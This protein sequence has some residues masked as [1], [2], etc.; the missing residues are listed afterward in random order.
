[1]AVGN[2]DHERISTAV[3]VTPRRLDQPLDLLGQQMLSL[4]QV[5]VFGAGRRLGSATV[6]FLV[7]GGTRWSF[8]LVIINRL[9]A[10]ATFPYQ[11]RNGTVHQAHATTSH[12]SQTD[13]V[14]CYVL[15][16]GSAC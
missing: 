3:P 1:M 5:F 6:P 4:A 15:R 14:R 10:M 2:Q 16:V 9:P 11:A 13:A 8:A 7:A 12:L